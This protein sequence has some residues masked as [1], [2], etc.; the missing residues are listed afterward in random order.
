MRARR[1]HTCRGHVYS[2]VFERVQ[3]AGAQQIARKVV[4]RVENKLKLIGETLSERAGLVQEI[5]TQRHLGGSEW[6]GGR[7]SGRICSGSHDSTTTVISSLKKA[8]AAS[9][10]GGMVVTGVGFA[11]A[12]ARDLAGGAPSLG[13]ADWVFDSTTASSR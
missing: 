9:R 7:R 4:W 12:E 2:E 3:N 1:A 10:G 8:S 6:R 5:G 13:T 11:T